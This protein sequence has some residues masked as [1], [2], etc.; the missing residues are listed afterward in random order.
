[1][2]ITSHAMG[3]TLTSFF[4][5][6]CKCAHGVGNEGKRRANPKTKHVSSHPCYERTL[7]RGARVAPWQAPPL[8][9]M[10]DRCKS[11]TLCPV[12]NIMRHTP[13]IPEIVLS[14][15]NAIFNERTYIYPWFFVGHAS[16]LIYNTRKMQH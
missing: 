4:I 12:E 15:I 10:V 1:M 9:Y 7:C 2:L 11:R 6:W 3:G 13:L 8:R 14:F 5:R 16:R